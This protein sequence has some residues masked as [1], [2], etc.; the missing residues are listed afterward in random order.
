VSSDAPDHAALAVERLMTALSGGVAAAPE[1][2][3]PVA[4]VFAFG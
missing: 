4:P 3:T 1:Q 2:R